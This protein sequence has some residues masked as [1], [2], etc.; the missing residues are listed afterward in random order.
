MITV[1]RLARWAGVAICTLL[2]A[3]SPAWG[4]GVQ[5]P[6]RIGSTLALTG[7]LA[8]TS[9]VHKTVGEIYVEQLNARNEDSTS[10]DAE[11]RLVLKH[12]IPDT[13]MRSWTKALMNGGM[14]RVMPYTITVR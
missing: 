2:V 14:L 3:T 5:P 8:A 10:G 13:Q 1:Q 11:M 4:Q 7:A 12:L 9:L 6:I